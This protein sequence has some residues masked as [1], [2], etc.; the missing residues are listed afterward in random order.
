MKEKAMGIDIS[1]ISVTRQADC[2][3]AESPTILQDYSSSLSGGS[4]AVG[5]FFEISNSF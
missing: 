4:L 2:G 5:F 3:A 1:F